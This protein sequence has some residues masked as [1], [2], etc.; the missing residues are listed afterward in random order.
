MLGSRGHKGYLRGDG[1][2]KRQISHMLERM[3]VLSLF[4][5]AVCERFH[6]A[7]CNFQEH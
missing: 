3:M 6:L 7:S 4:P 1:T 5:L 2:E